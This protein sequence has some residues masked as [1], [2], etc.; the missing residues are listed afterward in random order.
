MMYSLLSRGLMAAALASLLVLTGCDSSVLGAPEQ[1]AA[2]TRLTLRYEV[3]ATYASCTVARNNAL[4]QPETATVTTFPWTES[5]TVAVSA[6]TPF[7]ASIVA[8]C[9]DDT[10]AGKSDVFIFAGDDLV[11]AGSAAGFGASS[12]ATFEVTADG[13]GGT[14]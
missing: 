12:Y 13:A 6:N 7:V 3:R 9:A 11:A 5:H 14:R 8:T 1:E 4:R 10:K 2:V